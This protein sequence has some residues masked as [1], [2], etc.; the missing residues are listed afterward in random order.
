MLASLASKP[1]LELSLGIFFEIFHQGQ[2]HACFMPMIV[3]TADEAWKIF[4]SQQ[5]HILA[6]AAERA[7][8][9]EFENGEI[10]IPLIPA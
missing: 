8:A 4:D 1:A 9:G 3:R 7:E 2:K 6:V 10:Q 5:S